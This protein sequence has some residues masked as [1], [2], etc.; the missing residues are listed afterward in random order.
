MLTNTF[1]HAPGVGSITEL[2]LWEAGIRDWDA[3]LAPDAA[4]PLPRGRRDI[5]APVLEESR[6]RLAERDHRYFARV[7]PAIE[8]WRAAGE[9][10]DKLGFLD[11]ETTGM[12]GSSHPTVIGLFDFADGE[13]RTWIYGENMHEFADAIDEYETL[14]T[15]FG[16]GFDLP[17]LK[18]WDPRIQW[19]QIHVDLC[20]LLRRVGYRGGLKS[21]EKQ[22]GIQRP[23]EVDGMSGL[24]A[25]RL[26]QQYRRGNDRALEI[27]IEYNREDV[28]NMVRLLQIASQ[29]SMAFCGW[30]GLQP[31][32]LGL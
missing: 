7:L 31:T 30:T 10:S 8:H 9:F 29:K 26:W 18:A 2:Q 27:L 14:V 22:L 3:F 13:F 20:P 25:V 11:I 16:L 24:D 32:L 23:D 19:H 12:G 17:V 5:I 1:L 28:V 21:V 4:V 15:F 6:E